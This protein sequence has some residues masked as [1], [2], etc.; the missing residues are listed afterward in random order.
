MNRKET[1]SHS[2]NQWSREQTKRYP[3]LP[4]WYLSERLIHPTP[5]IGFVLFGL[6]LFSSR[7]PPLWAMKSIFQIFG[8]KKNKPSRSNSSNDLPPASNHNE[9]NSES[10]SYSSPNENTAQ[11]NSS[12]NY[13][14]EDHHQNSFGYD[15]TSS[16][17]LMEKA[18]R[19]M[20]RK[21]ESNLWEL[22]L[23]HEI[24]LLVSTGYLSSSILCSFVSSIDRISYK[25]SRYELN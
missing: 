5:W 20:K 4:V 18:D 1:N 3:Q 7:L 16:S 19:L 13:D 2:I 24:Q 8:K 25:C 17:P 11:N 9:P 14:N 23:P 21:S 22:L 6:S 15:P 12:G 10:S